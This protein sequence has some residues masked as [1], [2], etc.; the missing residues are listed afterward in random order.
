MRIGCDPRA[1]AVA[2][3]VLTACGTYTTYQTAEPLPPGRWQLSLA[4]TP[5]LFYDTPST[6]PT[7]TVITEIAARRGVGANTDVGLKFFSIGTELSVRHRVVDEQWQCAVLGA[8]AF[9]RTVESGGNTEALFG[10]LRL[11]AAV[12]RRTSARWAF[13]FGPM[14]TGSAYKFAG[15]GS[16][17]GLMAGAFANAQWTFGS[18]KRWHLIPELSM[19]A[20]VT[21][22]VPVDGLVTMV[23]LAVARD[24]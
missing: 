12:T 8:F 9:A 3:C 5:G 13:T 19:H 23:G 24:F 14:L 10:E 21:G 11:G 18:M 16:A 20:T 2:A 15:G 7:P 22:D 6:T 4:S 17:R 1:L